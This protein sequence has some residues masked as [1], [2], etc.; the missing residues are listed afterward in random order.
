MELTGGAN[1][2]GIIIPE[3]TTGE[4]TRGHSAIFVRTSFLPFP[5]FSRQPTSC[6]PTSE[7][8][9]R[10]DGRVI[11]GISSSSSQFDPLRNSALVGT[12]NLPNQVNSRADRVDFTSGFSSQLL[13]QA[14]RGAGAAV[15]SHCTMPQGASCHHEP[16]LMSS[17]PVAPNFV[18]A[19]ASQAN[20]YGARAEQTRPYYHQPAP[21]SSLH[22]QPGYVSQPWL[23]SQ[24]TFPH[25]PSYSQQFSSLP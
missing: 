19:G 2:T 23:S 13:G 10:D 15:Y 22:Y 18:T 1:A 24:Q 8:Q 12:C 4:A 21:S 5:A 6:A 3:T 9:R 11:N 17:V 16:P 25:G 20:I 7:Y 14:E